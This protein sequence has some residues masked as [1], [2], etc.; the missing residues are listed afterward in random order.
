[1]A[2]KSKPAP[3]VSTTTTGRFKI[4]VTTMTPQGR[5]SCTQTL[6][7]GYTLGNAIDAREALRLSMLDEVPK[8]ANQNSTVSDYAE[9][10]IERKAKRCRA[11][12][13][14]A[15][16]T[17][18]S[19]HI[20]PPLGH[21]HC[22]SVTRAD[23][24]DW[25]EFTEAQNIT[26]ET[27]RKRWSILRSLLGRMC[28]ELAIPDVTAHHDSPV[29]ANGAGKTR[30]TRALTT[31]EL[32]RLL[33]ALE[34]QS[35]RLHLEATVLAFTGLRVG[36]LY[37]VLWSDVDHVEG[38]LRVVDGKTKAARREVPLPRGVSDMLQA[39]RRRLIEVQH[40]GVASG[41]VFPSK[42]GTVKYPGPLWRA[43]RAAAE[44][45]GLEWVPH[46][47]TLRRTFNTMMLRA[48]VD[49]LALRA[50]MGHTDEK[51]TEHYADLGADDVRP[52]V[53][54]VWLATGG[55]E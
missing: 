12:T 14:K 35:N 55:G 28:A 41:L 37:A 11:S 13:V 18:L 48:G 24:S 3:G 22:A 15:Y 38:L 32:Q 49:K 20:L 45:A 9:R 16:T 25:L 30:C 23:V 44:K 26:G 8:R 53:E 19:A 5:R 7:A 36:E 42:S 10:W 52:L 31:K 50:V 54:S 17:I 27:A 51:M 4:R 43:I 33:A 29:T 34:Q 46:T 21:L 2:K 6:P 1:M 40:P 39:H 47:H